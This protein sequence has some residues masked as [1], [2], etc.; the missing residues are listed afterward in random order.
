MLD[1]MRVCTRTPKKGIMEIYPKF[2]VGRCSDL[3]IRGGDFYAVWVEEKGLWSTDE[4][5]ALRLIDKELDKYREENCKNIDDHIIVLH[6]WIQIAEALING[7]SIVKSSVGI[8]TSCS[9]RK[10][11]SPT[12]RLVRRIMPARDLTIRLRKVSMI[13]GISLLALY[14]LR[15]RELKL[16]G[17]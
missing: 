16:S 12:W 8:P 13:H 3:M 2:I 1:F 17:L 11:Y 5:D 4:D 14:I 15:M 10:L 9:M 6:M 7:I